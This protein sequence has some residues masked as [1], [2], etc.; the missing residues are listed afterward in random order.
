MRAFRRLMAI[1][2]V[3]IFFFFFHLFSFSFVRFLFPFSFFQDTTVK[4][5]KKG[6]LGVLRGWHQ[7][8]LKSQLVFLFFLFFFPQS[9]SIMCN[10]V[11][12]SWELGMPYQKTSSFFSIPCLRGGGVRCY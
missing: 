5:L 10:V 11:Q 6:G 4:P 8:F 7:L 3:L 1:L 12:L 9:C 2:Q